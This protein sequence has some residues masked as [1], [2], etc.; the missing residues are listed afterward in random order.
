MNVSEFKRDFLEEVSLSAEKSGEGRCA[1]FVDKMAKN[2]CE[3]ELLSS[4]E[5]CFCE[6]IN[7]RKKYRIDGYSYDDFDETLNLIV[8]DFDGYD[9]S[10]TLVLTDAR[11]AFDRALEFI[12][13]ALN[14]YE[15]GMDGNIE[16]NALALVDLL[17]EVKDN[18]RGIRLYL[19]T[20]ATMSTRIKQI[21]MPTY[22][23]L[24]VEA[25][26][27]DL[28]R[29][30]EACT[31][32][33][34]EDIVID[35]NEY[36]VNGG[37]PCIQAFGGNTLK[38]TSYLGI[39]PGSVL[40]EIYKKFGSKLLEGNVRSFL[41]TKVA[42]NKK[43]RDTILRFPEMFFAFNNGIAVTAKHIEIANQCIVKV[44]DFQIINGG[45]TTASLY[46]ARQKDRA[47]LDNI[48]VPMK[49]TVIDDENVTEEEAN[50]FVRDISR[51]SNS[52]NKV[53]DADFFAS[54]PFHR[55]IERI[56][57]TLAAPAKNGQQ[58]ETRWYYE[59]ARG[60]YLQE[61]MR[62]TDAERRRFLEKNPKYQVITKTD[63][64]KVH[65]SWNGHPDV[66]S[67]GAQ[68]QFTQFAKKYIDDAWQEKP[69]QFNDLFYRSTV[70]L[71]IMYQFLAESIPKQSWYQGGY[72]ANIITYTMALF[73]RLIQKQ[74][75][76]RDL[77]L[78]YIWNCQGLKP[79]VQA[80][81]LRI[82]EAVL[83]ELTR[84][85]RDVENV[86]QWCK[87][88]KCWDCVQA[89]N[90]PLVCEDEEAVKYVWDDLD[91]VPVAKPKE[92]TFEDCLISPE[93]Q[94]NIRKI[95]NRNQKK[96]QGIDAQQE[97]Y[98][99]SASY[100]QALMAFV[101]TNRLATLQDKKAL[102]V[103]VLIPERMPNAMQSKRLIELKKRAVEAG[104]TFD[105]E[106]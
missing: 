23:N 58:Y 90:I 19:F 89:L 77:D 86:T 27:W 78:D 43:I 48:Y 51:S 35:F 83:R 73:H 88:Q 26:V 32:P 12:N 5:P 76:G 69:E 9:L 15:L 99:L 14:S 85:D 94:K 80:A 16:S 95:A 64:A 56:S 38:Y 22:G 42:V 100:W 50:N 79:P 105:A 106:S 70:A 102:D 29:L 101:M 97:V 53:S 72:R 8:A 55:Q 68:F 1:A 103:A 81:L 28:A 11:Q 96:Q 39:I 59:R 54:H 60:Q 61:Q 44:R 87:R 33:E 36:G 37:I 46:T 98:Q 3:C 17:Q 75:P 10:R 67:K 91:S 24:S 57:R 74:Y 21:D 47:D 66:V 31:S 4:F 52:Q 34:H 84:S 30:F 93:E 104:F 92:I 2:L 13:A 62:L 25:H 18:L 63:L 65:N 7:K 82:A 45:Q 49:L 40:A 6:G 20:D 71:T 41:S